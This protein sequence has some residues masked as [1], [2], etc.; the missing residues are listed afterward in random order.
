[1]GEEMEVEKG[2]NILKIFALISCIVLFIQTFIY[3]FILWNGIL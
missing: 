2:K 3:Y 1:M